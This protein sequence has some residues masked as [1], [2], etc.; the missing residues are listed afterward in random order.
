MAA[1]ELQKEDASYLAEKSYQYELFPE[2][3]ELHVII[4]EFPFPTSLYSPSTA[5][6]LI[7]IPPGYPNTQL[8]MFWTNPEIKKVDGQAPA[9]SETR[10][11]HHGRSWQRWSRHYASGWR[12]GI[13]GLRSFIQSINAELLTGR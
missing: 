9:A 8:D 2:N 7:K 10:E 5:E 3:N 13:D 4:K 12:P 11:Q 1:I 6:L